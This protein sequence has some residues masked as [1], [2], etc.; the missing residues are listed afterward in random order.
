MYNSYLVY[1]E[2]Y[3]KLVIESFFNHLI[4]TKEITSLGDAGPAI[5]RYFKVFDKFYLSLAQSRKARAGKT[6]ESTHNSLF[7]MLKYPFDEQIVIDGKPDFLMP[8][9]EHYRKNPMECIIFT[10]KRYCQGKMETN[11]NRRN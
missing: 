4:D 10:A 7:K 5:S 11:C 2:E 9:A 6:F 1:E 8:S 3:G